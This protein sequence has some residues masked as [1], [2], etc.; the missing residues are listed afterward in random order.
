MEG[1]VALLRLLIERDRRLRIQLHEHFLGRDHGAGEGDDH[2]HAGGLAV[3]ADWHGAYDFQLAE[4]LGDRL[5]VIADPLDG[6]GRF[7]VDG[8]VRLR[9]GCSLQL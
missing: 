4:L 2:D 7:L 5:S 8:G 6:R 3:A 9:P 1:E